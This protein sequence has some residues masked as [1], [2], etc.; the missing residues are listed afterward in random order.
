MTKQALLFIPD[1]SGFTEFV[2]HTAINHSRHIISELLELLL[3]AN[4]MGLELAEIEGDALFLYKLHDKLDVVQ[5]KKQ[6]E[7]MYLAFHTHLKRYEYQRICHCGAC[8]SAHNL[9]IKFVVHYGEIE[10]MKVKDSKKPYGS[11]VIQVHRLLKNEVPIDE[12]ALFTESVISVNNQTQELLTATYDFGDISF[13]YEPLQSLKESLPEIPLIP[14]DVP[15]HKLVDIAEVINLPI[16]DLYEII[17]NFDYRLLWTV[18]VD[19]MEYDKNRMNRLEEKHKCLFNKQKDV[20]ISTVTKEVK[21]NQLVY[22]ESTADIPFTNRI[23]S[24]YV[25]EEIATN[26]TKLRIESFADFKRLGIL[27]KPLMKSKLNKSFSENLKAL[28]ELV[29]SGFSLESVKSN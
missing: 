21:K 1:I 22:G 29:E 13:T 27:M 16:D 23:S 28:I 2:H 18:G 9:K 26:R 10:F 11:N 15:K 6:I 24:Y 4:N 12:Y 7:S 17:S 8:T 25:L 14:D 19:G 3:D 5:I 20:N